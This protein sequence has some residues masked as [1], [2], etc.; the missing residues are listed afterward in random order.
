MTKWLKLKVLKESQLLNILLPQMNN[1]NIKKTLIFRFLI[2][3]SKVARYS[4]FSSF[5]FM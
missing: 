1:V 2:L 3:F 5:I 4:T